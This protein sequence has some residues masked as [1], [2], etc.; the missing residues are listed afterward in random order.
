MGS[1]EGIRSAAD[2]LVATRSRATGAAAAAVA[3]SGESGAAGRIAE[4]LSPS[5]PDAGLHRAVSLRVEGN[6]EA[7]LPV[8]RELAATHVSG[9]T[10]LD[11][12]FLGEAAL[13][14]GRPEEAATALRRFGR[15]NLPLYALAWAYP[16]G[17]LLLA[18]AEEASGR[19]P[20]ARAA[21]ASLAGFWRDAEPGFPP[22]RELG[23][24]QARLG[25]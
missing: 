14:S 22:L 8:L 17:L 15:M 3:W 23:E 18:R 6:P 2:A 24:L 9:S 4:L 19:L 1:A 16:R 25:R 20:E 21:A 7:A 5:S 12:L 11:S 10:F 13:A